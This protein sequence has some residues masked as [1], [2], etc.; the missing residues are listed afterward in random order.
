MRLMGVLEGSEGLKRK[1]KFACISCAE[2]I[3]FD[4]LRLGT[5][6]SAGIVWEAEISGTVVLH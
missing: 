5:E 2:K 1:Q 4:A 3:F 6:S